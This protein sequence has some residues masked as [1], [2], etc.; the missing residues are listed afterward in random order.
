MIISQ[1]VSLL[2][3]FLV[4]VFVECQDDETTVSYLEI[5]HPVICEE[6]DETVFIVDLRF[7]F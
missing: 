4:V 1:R 6:S 7:V 3:L 5:G 2:F